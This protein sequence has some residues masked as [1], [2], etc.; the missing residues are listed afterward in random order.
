[1]EAL[2]KMRRKTSYIYLLAMVTL[3]LSAT[4][5]TT[6]AAEKETAYNRII[7]TQTI[8]C[9][10]VPYSVYFQIDPNT[11][12]KS[13]IMHDV[14]EEI[15]RLMGFKVEWAEEL[16]WATLA[17]SIQNGR[18]DAFCSGIWIDTQNGRFLGFTQPLY[19]NTV[20]AYGKVGGKTFSSIEEIND[21]SVRVLSRDGGTPA[22]IARQ[23]FPKATLIENPSGISDGELLQQLATDKADVLFFGDDM[24]TDYMAKNPGKV[25]P[26]FPKQPLRVYPAAIAMPIDDPAL[27]N[28]FN[29]AISELKGSRFIEKTIKKYNYENH[30][31]THMD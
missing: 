20:S 13:G 31:Q 25:L 9:G 12:E 14:V 2:K 18:V 11:G 6:H 19:Y 22:I 10:Y 15:G 21:P 1:M 17:P 24:M 7:R 8:R 30:I 29:N 27:M 16:T 28:M 26:L 4:S 23:D 5:F 3:L